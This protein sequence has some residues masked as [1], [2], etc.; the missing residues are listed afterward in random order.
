ML[1]MG[2]KDEMESVFESCGAKTASNGV[3]ILLFSA[4]MPDWVK[5]MA[6]TYMSSNRIIIDL[7]GNSEV[8][9]HTKDVSIL[10]RSTH[11]VK[12]IPPAFPN[13]GAGICGCEAHGSTV[14][15]EHAV[16]LTT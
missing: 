12:N 6:T 13:V 11:Y 3:Q 7:V 4:T 10:R 1:D 8:T 14:S 15:L 9:I 5:K 2:F 16:L